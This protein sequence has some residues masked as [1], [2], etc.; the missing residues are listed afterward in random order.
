MFPNLARRLTD[1]QVQCSLAP[2]A[3]N[4]ESR[5]L[6]KQIAASKKPEAAILNVLS[7]HPSYL[8]TNRQHC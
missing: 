6:R 8:L 3:P 5:F 7:D 1:F 4:V 2:A